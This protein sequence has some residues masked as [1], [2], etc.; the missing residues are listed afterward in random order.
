MI[1]SS[2]LDQGFSTDAEEP[3]YAEFYR[4]GQLKSFRSGP[5]GQAGTTIVL[6][7]DQG[8]EQGR[9]EET[10]IAFEP[11]EDADGGPEDFEYWVRDTIRRVYERHHSVVR[12]G[13]CEKSAAEVATLIAGPVSYIC[14]ECV[15]TCAAILEDKAHAAEGTEPQ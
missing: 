10:T 7:L 8:G 2:Y 9:V 6:L 5:P 15:C 13:F 1:D 3:L 4:N 12:C 11:D 14:D